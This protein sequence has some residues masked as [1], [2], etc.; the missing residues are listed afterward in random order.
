MRQHSR[1]DTLRGGA[2]LACGLALSPLLSLT[3][4]G[5]GGEGKYI[6][7]MPYA[8]KFADVL[9]SR[10]AYAEHG[11]GDPIVFLHGNPTS[12]YLWRNVMPHCQEYGRMI[13][14]DL[15]GMG[16]SDKLPDA[17]AD[18]YSFDEHRT[19]LD[20]LL[21]TLGVTENVTLVL[22]DWGSGLGFDWAHRHPEAIKGI[23][24]MEAFLKP[25][26]SAEMSEG[27]LQ[28][29]NGMRG[30]GGEEA[31]LQ[32]NMFVEQV[33]IGGLG[34]NLDDADKR[35][36][37]QAYLSQGDSRLPTLK[38]P[39]EVPIDGQPAN[40][41]AILEAYSNWLLT[42]EFPKLLISAT[43][44]AILV[45]ERLQF[46]RSL[47]NQTEVNVAGN[48]YIQEQA[49]AEVGRAIRAWLEEIS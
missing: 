7:N 6:G 42:T 26:K 17:N 18:S 4:C 28:F 46:A 27:A 10:M 1:R 5:G 24:Y 29:F 15:I 11:E 16:L 31:I 38:W 43:P 25:W 48:H 45:D 39:R 33:L 30:P 35:A 47:P 36:Y 40:T 13:A 3:A 32:N 23:A 12:S 14:P 22:H 44:G 19:Y 34:D 2:A 21:E 41:A 9:G 49:P 20:A 8:M 37:R